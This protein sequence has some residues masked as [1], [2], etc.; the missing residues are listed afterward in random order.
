MD[1]IFDQNR[2]S[3]PI[4]MVRALRRY[5]N[6][7]NISQKLRNF[8]FRLLFNVGSGY[9]TGVSCGYNTN[10]LFK[11]KIPPYM[12]FVKRCFL[13]NDRYNTNQ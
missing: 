2:K 5:K 4:Y 6:L 1:N 13:E 7:K 10:H 11:A 3:F 9:S 8:P 12:I